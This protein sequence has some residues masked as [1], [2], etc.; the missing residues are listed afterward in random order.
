MK[1]RWIALFMTCMMAVSLLVGCGRS[2]TEETKMKVELD[3][4]NPVTLKIWH[5]YNG[6]QQATFDKLLDKFNATVGKKQGIYVEGYGHG[7]VADLEKAI[8]S[9]VNEE[10]GAE[11]MPDIFSTYADTAYSIEKKGKLADLS[12]YFTKKELSKYVDSYI[13]EGYLNNDKGLYLLPVAKS[14]EIL[15]LNKTD[16]EPFAKACNVSV[17]DLKTTEGITKVAK[18][19]YEWTDAKTPNVPNDGKAFYGRDSMSNYFVIGMK[20]MGKEIFEVKDGNVTVNTDKK[21]LKRLW[22]NYYVPYVSG[23]FA[24]YGKFRS[25]DVKTENI[26]AYTGSTSSAFYFPQQVEGEDSSHKIDYE[27]L[28]APIMEGGEN[29]KVQQGAGMAVTK[30]DAGHEYAASVFLKWFSKKEQNLEFVCQSSYMPVLKEANNMKSIDKVIKEKKLKMDN[31]TYDCMKKIIDNFDST[32]FYTSK[33]F[34]N[35]YSMRKVLDYNLSDQAA[36]D[37]K[38]IDKEIKAGASRETVLKKYTSKEAFES[39]Y[40]QFCTALKKAHDTK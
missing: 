6:T 37:K 10:V 8:T 34:E 36:A 15:L 30:S 29:Y 1:K 5:Y 22:E 25:D 21:L 32:K 23:Y 26:L 4:D 27:V 17:E 33:T 16:W 14:T 12:Q 9:S 39:W 40:K 20:Q 18:K 11:D 2:K 24:A 35:G 19:Y 13:K 28:E 7:S 38:A 31:K 3:P